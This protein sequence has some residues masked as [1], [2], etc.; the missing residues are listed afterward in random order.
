LKYGTGDKNLLLFNFLPDWKTLPMSK[1]MEIS[2]FTDDQSDQVVTLW[3]KCILT[4]S[5]N[6]PQKDIGCKNSDLNGNFL[7][8]KLMGFL[9]PQSWLAMMSIVVALII[10]LS[11]LIIL[12]RVMAS[13]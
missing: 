12:A 9:W 11:I 7:W 13:V 6:D 4:C 1:V 10:W 3:E 8:A 2:E 5:W